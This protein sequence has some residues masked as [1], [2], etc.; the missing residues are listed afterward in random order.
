VTPTD[1]GD[2]GGYCAGCGA[3]HTRGQR[4]CFL[5]GEPLDAPVGEQ[6]APFDPWVGVTLGRYEI[7][8]VVASGGMGVVYAARDPHLGRTIALKLLRDDLSADDEFRRRFVRESRSA[9]S[10]DH[11]NILPVFDAG[12]IDGI[13]YIATRLVDARDLRHLLAEEGQLPVD[14]A[15]SIT[16]QI[17]SAL[18]FAHTRGTVHRDVKPAN[19]L[20]MPGRDGDPD[21]AYL[22]DFGI[23]KQAA[24]R[25]L[26]RSGMFIGTPDYVAP[27]QASGLPVDGRADQYALACVLHHCLVGTPPFAPGGTLD[28]LQAHRFGTLPRIKEGRPDLPDSIE[29]A[30]LRALSKD[31]EER[32]MSCRAFV[33]AA[34]AGTGLE[35][36]A[37]P[38]PQPT[39]RL[40]AQPAMPTRAATVA[41]AG[42]A[43]PPAPGPRRVP[44]I[45]LAA[46]ALFLLAAAGVAAGVLLGRSDDPK[47]AETNPSVSTGKAAST[48]ARTTTRPSSTT[49]AKAKAKAQRP[50]TIPANLALSSFPR[51]GYSVD[52]PADWNRENVDEEISPTYLRTRSE[53]I[54]GSLVVL[55]DHLTDPDAPPRENRDAVRRKYS[56]TKQGFEQIGPYR[57]SYSVDTT[58]YEIRFRY[59]SNDREVRRVEVML[60]KSD[61]DDFVI[62]AGGIAVWQDLSVLANRVADSIELDE[63]GSAG[64]GG[65]GGAGGSDPPDDDLKPD[66][67]TYAGNAE[68]PGSSSDDTPISMTFRDAAAEASY[69]HDGE[70]CSSTLSP[71]ET[72]GDAVLWEETVDE[73]ACPSGVWRITVDDSSSSIKAVWEPAADS[74]GSAADAS[75]TP[76]Q[77]TL[78]PP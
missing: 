11:P 65:S 7:Q 12:E 71:S 72:D 76:I 23:T 36:Y 43:P 24:D 33:V 18:D 30:L 64:S 52:L 56:T 44:A 49:P 54:D 41:Q 77:A 53:T 6:A 8:R 28:V 69:E 47:R 62:T 2:V 48:V 26:T 1:G 63:H 17:A 45:A 20:V 67:R 14:R 39:A 37:T 68:E 9:A 60:R 4:Y 57:Q 66:L 35:S 31:R 29:T 73:G 16:S 34:R 38:R 50:V 19:I 25:S 15:L 42:A 3:S 46:V 22:I 74:D 61:H 55:V 75:A 21:H 70:T 78:D 59:T 58:A 10:L 27:E 5:C 13:L 40:E 32:Y 51:T